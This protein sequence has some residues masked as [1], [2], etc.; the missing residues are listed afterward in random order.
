MNDAFCVSL[1]IKGLNRT[2]VELKHGEVTDRC[3]GTFSL[4][5]T[6][7]ELKHGGETVLLYG[8]RGLNRTFVELKPLRPFSVREKRQVLI[9]PLWN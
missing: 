7:V 9:E 8:I 3:S 4:N 6:F 5:R 1:S 2:F